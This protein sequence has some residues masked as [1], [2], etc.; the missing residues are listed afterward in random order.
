M[1]GQEDISDG[2]LVAIMA[3]D[4]IIISTKKV[5]LFCEVVEKLKT[6]TP[7]ELLV[8]GADSLHSR[9]FFGWLEGNNLGWF[10]GHVNCF[11]SGK[12]AMIYS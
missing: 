10:P 8:S 11:V 5:F 1:N 6:L 9:I 2:E 12:S 4:N 7:P 3:Y